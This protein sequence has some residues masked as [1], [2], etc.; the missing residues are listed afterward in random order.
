MKP[1]KR[2]L[3]F[4]LVFVFAIAA[5][6][7]GRNTI[8]GRW[9]IDGQ[10]TFEFFSDGTF[11]ET[12]SRGRTETGTWRTDGN[13]LSMSW[14]DETVTM[15]FNVSGNTLTIETDRETITLTRAR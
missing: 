13:R 9:Q 6:G 4:A 2:I 15:D 5:C 14:W 11:V 8:I 1:F 3:C 7:G 10:D 12:D